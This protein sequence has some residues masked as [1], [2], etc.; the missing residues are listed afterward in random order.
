[1]VTGAAFFSVNG[2]DDLSVS[3]IDFN[4]YL[5]PETVKNDVAPGV[6]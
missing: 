6:S 5:C 2:M 1:V 3:R 4:S